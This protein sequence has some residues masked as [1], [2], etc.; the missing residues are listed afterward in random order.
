MESSQVIKIDNYGGRV[1]STWWEST[2]HYQINKWFTLKLSSD[3]WF[4][5][6]QEILSVN[7]LGTLYMNLWRD[8]EYLWVTCRLF[9]KL[10][11]LYNIFFTMEGYQLLYNITKICMKLYEYITNYDMEVKQYYNVIQV[12]IS[13]LI[14][15][16]LI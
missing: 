10:K 13:I 16:K 5:N 8:Q 14:V 3:E 11:I 12:F 6:L 9:L 2:Y 4:W 7:P 1:L 15:F